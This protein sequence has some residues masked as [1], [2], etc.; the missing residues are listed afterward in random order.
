MIHQD[1][2]DA[3]NKAL[4]LFHLNPQFRFEI[5]NNKLAICWYSTWNKNREPKKVSKV[6]TFMS[7]GSHYPSFDLPTGGTMTTA[8]G[9][10]VRW[11]RGMPCFPISVFHYWDSPNVGLYQDDMGKPSPGPSVFSVLTEAGYPE[12]VKCVVC[13]EKPDGMDWWS[14]EDVTGPCCNY[15]RC[16]KS[17]PLIEVMHKWVRVKTDRSAQEFVCLNCLWCTSDPV[18]GLCKKTA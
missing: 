15:G 14:D 6:W 4:E 13:G 7:K 3:A 11:I 8:L 1:R 2:L 9:Q 5:K 18:T 12:A 10:L 17:K 16:D